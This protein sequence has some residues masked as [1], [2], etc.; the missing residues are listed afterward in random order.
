MKHRPVAKVFS[1]LM[2]A[3]LSAS[4]SISAIMCFAETFELKC[5]FSVVCAVCASAALI[6]S[7]SVLPR[8]GGLVAIVEAGVLLVV[9][10]WQWLLVSGSFQAVLYSVTTRLTKSFHLK[11]L[12]SGSGDPLWFLLLAGVLLAWAVAWVCGGKG[13]AVPLVLACLPVFVS[14]LLVVD[15]APLFWLVLLTGALLLL[16]LTQGARSR[17]PV[18][19]NCLA[20]LLLV[21]T[22]ALLSAIILLSPP[23]EYER[24]NWI[25]SLREMAEEGVDIDIDLDVSI[26]SPFV[27]GTRWA[28]Q[29]KTVDLSQLGPKKQT[30]AH[31]L[32]FRAASEISY[33]RGVSL[34]VYGNNMWSAV[35]PA[36]FAAEGFARQPQITGGRDMKKLE[37]RTDSRRPLL[38]TAYNLSAV[39]D[40]ATAVDDAYLE[41][42]GKIKEYTTYY[43][44]WASIPSEAY[45]AYVYR[46]YT[47]L[48]E[49]LREPLKQYCQ[50]NGLTGAPAWEIARHVQ[51]AG[52]YD[53]STPQVPEGED[54]VL[55]FLR[56]GR[57]GYCVHFA[58][59]AVLLLRAEGIPARYVTGY[60]VSGAADQWNAVTEDQ[61]HAWVEYY[62]RGVGWEVLDPT[63][64][65]W[66][67]YT[68]EETPVAPETPEELAP[69]QD[70]E[71]LPPDE[72]LPEKL[73]PEEPQAVVPLPSEGDEGTGVTPSGG[74]T[75]ASADNVIF[76]ALKD[77]L[78]RVFRWL[79][80]PLLLLLLVTVRRRLILCRRS[81]LCTKQHPNNCLLAYWQWLVRLSEAGGKACDPLL[82]QLAEKARFSQHTICEEELEQIRRAVD[83]EV[84]R[85]QA[86][87][88]LKRL[89]H[90]YGKVLY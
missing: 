18:Q 25:D 38:Y 5:E 39:P 68:P 43:S 32:D 83:E 69:E 10:L 19:G 52:V 22:A 34:G 27:G 78:Q 13:S 7:V 65:D 58:S 88:A 35:D 31:A 16:L 21:P 74:E 49:E 23:E 47:Q 59:A 40:G 85:L 12:G 33:L 66:Q 48:P 61:A 90:R 24:T 26:A 84:K 28:R 76:A 17:E 55:Y 82:L 15:I 79:M 30:G 80:A 1:F 86:A 56:E 29:L 4:I 20:W 51:G 44:S 87:H 62:Q 42:S 45:D 3:L 60:S 50:E 77:L 41:N 72:P 54:F 64:P 36:E 70:G 73:E 81:R 14:C 6:F 46:N 2:T 9:L 37:V 53:L 8:R 67:S 75:A 11:I 63:P 57:R 89:W 71:E